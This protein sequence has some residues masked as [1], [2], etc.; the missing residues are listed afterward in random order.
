M[1]ALN[2]GGG[3]LLKHMKKKVITLF[4]K[5]H[6]TASERNSNPEYMQ[7]KQSFLCV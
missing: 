2:Q 1:G 4:Q 6:L 7:E 3:G 5:K